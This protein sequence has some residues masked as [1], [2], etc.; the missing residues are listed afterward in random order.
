MIQVITFKWS[1]PGYRSQFKGEYVNALRDMV[2]KHTTVPHE[3][4]C[5]TDDPEGIDPDIRVIP[6]WENPA[7]DYGG[8]DRPN[9]FYRL[10]MFSREMKYLIGARFVWMDLDT[11][12]LGNIDHILSDKS[13]FKIWRVEDEFMPCN[14]SM[15]LHRAGSRTHIWD[16]FKANLVDPSHG[17]KRVNGF[18]GSDQAWIAQHLG[19]DDG[20]FGK[21]DGVYSFRCHIR[22]RT[23]ELPVGAKI[24][25]FHGRSDPWH[26]DI[27]DRYEWV[28][29]N[30]PWKAVA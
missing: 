16:N 26:Y 13:D 4:V 5:I 6:L 28:R 20:Y 19:P 2:K 9:C 30:Y 25:F 22:E 3:F 24:V 29:D 23:N 18:N 11:L 21:P 1:K 17:L 7:P 10:K 15:V 12:I 8:E 27:Q 14:G